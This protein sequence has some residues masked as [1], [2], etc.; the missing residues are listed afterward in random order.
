VRLKIIEKT[1]RRY[2]LSG[3]VSYLVNP[4]L[5]DLGF[6]R[7]EILYGIAPNQP[8]TSQSIREGC[9]ALLY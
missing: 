8:E 9:Q 3:I 6:G 2:M 7:E 1:L 4:L 5:T